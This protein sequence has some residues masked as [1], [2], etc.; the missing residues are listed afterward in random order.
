MT[1]LRD[2]EHLEYAVFCTNPEDGHDGLCWIANDQ[3]WTPHL[4]TAQHRANRLGSQYPEHT[5]R[6]IAR[7][8]SDPYFI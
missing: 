2:D 4:G 6:I 3:Q 1:A 8:C 7:R 5:Y